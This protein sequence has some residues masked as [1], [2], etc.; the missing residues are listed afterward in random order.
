[1][2]FLKILLLLLAFCAIMAE[3]PTYGNAHVSK[4]V[5]VYDGDTFFA[6]L[7]G[8]H[9]VIGQEVGIRIDGI[10]TPELSLKTYLK[11]AK[12]VAD[13]AKAGDVHDL[14]QAAKL[15]VE[16][17]LKE[18][19]CVVLTNIKRGKYFRLVATIMVD[20]SDLGKELLDKGFAL[21]YDGGKK[22]DWMKASI[23]KEVKLDASIKVIQPEA[24]VKKK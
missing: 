1:M 8:V 24:P 22:T 6:D 23:E 9:P 12:T 2:K 18:S 14:A 20:G 15:Y 16:K 21:P 3:E 5:R 13:S 7:T 19:S 17:R 11:K 10:D 4:V